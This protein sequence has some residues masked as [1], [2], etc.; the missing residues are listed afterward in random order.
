M[1]ARNRPQQT[2][3]TCSCVCA[4]QTNRPIARSGPGQ[5]DF[6]DSCVCAGQKDNAHG[7]PRK[8]WAGLLFLLFLMGL[9]A[10]VL[11]RDLSPAQLLSALRHFNPIYLPAGFLLIIGYVSCEALCT[12]QILRRLGHPVLF[13]R[14]LGYSFAGFYFSS[15]TPS[16]TGGQP[17]QICY[18]S[19]DQIPAA[20]GA[21]DM[22]LIA[23][24]YQTATLLWSGA[25]ALFLPGVCAVMSERL[26]PLLFYGA[27]VMILLPLAMGIMM[28]FPGFAQRICRGLL[29][30]LT[31][32]R[33]IRR[34]EK[35]QEALRRQLGEYAAGASCIRRNPWL[36]L[37]VLLLCI[38]QLGLLYSVPWIVARAF[39]VDGPAWSTIAGLQAL[40]TLAVCNLPLPGAVGPAEGGF[41]AAFTPIFGAALITPAMLV[42]RGISFYLFLPVSFAVTAAV[43]LRTAHRGPKNSGA[44]VPVG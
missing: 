3:F 2:D 12:W 10:A 19:R 36:A 32:L 38:L 4:G 27:A 39:G 18:M 41:I 17:A 15:V 40:L 11:L 26:G 16:A 20:H 34:P 31:A 37:R 22:M 30:L 35:T 44:H 28:F 13:R 7:R 21:L 8:Q 9:T 24:C 23:A 5:T 14:C 25:C 1:S 43:H 6:T 42:S 29:R 33:L